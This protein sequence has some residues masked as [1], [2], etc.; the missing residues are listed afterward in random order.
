MTLMSINW[1]EEEAE[2]IIRDRS[3]WVRNLLI[4][5]DVELELG[6]RKRVTRARVVEEGPGESIAI[7]E[8]AALQPG[9]AE[10]TEDRRVLGAVKLAAKRK[11]SLGGVG[12]TG[13]TGALQGNK[14]GSEGDT[15]GEFEGIPGG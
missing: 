1:V 11:G 7:V 6:G 4:T 9:E 10:T 5:P 8:A 12:G 15:E 3:D 2:T 14:G 13:G